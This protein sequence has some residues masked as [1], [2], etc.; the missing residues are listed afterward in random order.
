M[1]SSEAQESNYLLML[2]I[3]RRINNEW[4]TQG[5]ETVSGSVQR[6]TLE[7]PAGADE[8]EFFTSLKSQMPNRREL[9]S[10]SGLLCGPSNAW[11]NTH[12]DSRVLY[13]LDAQQHYGVYELEQAGKLL[14]VVI[15]VVRRGN[16]S[17]MAQIEEVAPASSGARL[18]TPAKSIGNAIAELGYFSI[19]LQ[20]TDGQNL[21]VAAAQLQQL[22]DFIQADTGRFTLVG[23]DYRP[24]TDNLVAATE[25]AVA[26]QALLKSRG[27]KK[28][29]AVFSVGRNAPAGRGASPVRVDLVRQ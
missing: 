20:F 22:V 6:K 28:P 1:Y 15:Y 12:F 25:H 29:V 27:L 14:Y 26:L 19:P 4:R 7:L 17:V 13:G 5:G 18:V 3:Y 16:G 10:C 23:H 11:A 9:F 8:R 21:E 24:G 2:G